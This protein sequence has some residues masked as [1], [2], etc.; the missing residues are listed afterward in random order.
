LK[1]NTNG[2]LRFA[3]IA[4]VAVKGIDGLFEGLVGIA[5]AVLGT[6]GIYDLVIQLTAPELDVHPNNKAV[7]LLRH[8]ASHLAHASTQ[9]V[10][11][12]LLAHGFLKLA[13]AIELLRGKPWIFPVAAAI[14]SGFV[15]YMTYKLVGGYSPWML[16]LA[17][18][19]LITVALVL[20][21]WR[22]HRARQA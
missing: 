19:D 22:S 4:A 15:I 9:F 1:Y 2:L 14:L 6:Q 8:G 16:A 17:L 5:V 20:N 7:H 11:I 13:L 10:E 12:W 3:F 18:F 21:E